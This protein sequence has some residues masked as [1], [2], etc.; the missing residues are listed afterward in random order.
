MRRILLNK[1]ELFLQKKLHTE[2]TVDDIRIDWPNRIIIEN[3]Y[4]P[5]PQNDTL[6][7]IGLL[8]AKIHLLDLLDKEI[9]THHLIAR[10]VSGTLIRKDSI[11][12]FQFI[13]DAFS[14]NEVK[15]KETSS[16]KSGTAL[17]ISPH[18]IDLQN[19]QFNMLDDVSGLDMKVNAGKL[20]MDKGHINFY[21][22][23]YYVDNTFCN[24]ISVDMSISKQT[25]NSQIQSKTTNPLDSIN[26]I[27]THD[28]IVLV[29]NI[30]FNNISYNLDL[31]DTKLNL[32]TSLSNATGKKIKVNISKATTHA[33]LFEVEKPNIQLQMDIP[34]SSPTSKKTTS[35]ST[36]SFSWSNFPWQTEI[37]SF[38]ITEGEFKMDNI[39]YPDTSKSMDFN[40]LNL[41]N[42]NI[43]WK[44][45]YIFNDNYR[46][47]LVHSSFMEKSGLFLKEFKLKGEIL[48]EKATFEDIEIFTNN[49][50][51]QSKL[52]ISYDNI[53]DV[54]LAKNLKSPRLNLTINPSTINLKDISYLFSNKFIN[55]SS[56]SV[57]K[58][59]GTIKKSN[60]SAEAK[61]IL[62]TL[63]DSSIMKLSVNVTNPFDSLKKM[64]IDAKLDTLHLRKIDLEPFMPDNL[65]INLPKTINGKLKID[66]NYNSLKSGL[67]LF[68]EY[69][70]V[71]VKTRM[72]NGYFINDLSLNQINL[73]EILENESLGYL[74]FH[75]IASGYVGSK[76]YNIHLKSIIKNIEFN[77]YN[78]T[79]IHI[80][81]LLNPEKVNAL[82]TSVESGNKMNLSLDLDSLKYI[83]A[84]NL[85]GNIDDLD[86]ITSEKGDTS[87]L[88]TTF[89][90]KSNGISLLKNNSNLDI[91][92]FSFHQ[93][94]NK[95]DFENLNAQ[96]NLDSMKA[97]MLISSPFLE[98][99]FNSIGSLPNITEQLKHLFQ[100]R[101]FA[102]D[103][104]LQDNSSSSYSL[105]GKI[106]SD[107]LLKTGYLDFLDTLSN[108]DFTSK[109][110]QKSELF[111]LNI[112]MPSLSIDS[113]EFDST[114]LTLSNH[115]KKIELNYIT[116]D[117]SVQDSINLGQI[118]FEGKYINDTSNYRFQIINKK[119][120][121]RVDIKGKLITNNG[122]I[123]NTF[124]DKMI[125][126]KRLWEIPKNNEIKI[127]SN[128]VSFQHFKITSGESYIE[129]EDSI[130][131]NKNKFLSVKINQIDLDSI[132]YIP[133]IDKWLVG[134]ELSTKISQSKKEVTGLVEINHLGFLNN[135]IGNLSLD[136]KTDTVQN[137]TYNLHTSLISKITAIKSH[138]SF[139]KDNINGYLNINN[140]NLNKLC[141][142]PPFNNYVKDTEGMVNA[143]LTIKGKSDAPEI[144]GFLELKEIKSTYKDLN[145][146]LYIKYNKILFE[147][148][149]VEINDLTIEDNQKHTIKANGIIDL[150]KLSDPEFNIKTVAD[151]F[152]VM[153][154][155]EKD[156]PIYYGDL[157][158]SNKSEIT[159]KLS[160]L[161][162][163]TTTTIEKGSHV[164]YVNSESGLSKIESS[165]GIVYFTNQL[166][167]VTNIPENSEW[168]NFP[169][170]SLDL[171]LKANIS[172]NQ[173]TKISIILD[174]IS[175][176]QINIEGGGNLSFLYGNNNSLTG[177]FE[178]N[179]G[180]Y[181][182]RLYGIIDK[183][184][185]L[186]KGST[187]TWTGDPL[188]PDLK[189]TALYKIRTSPYPL[190]T[191]N[192]NSAAPDNATTKSQTFY[193]LM[194]ING[195][196]E[197]PE[198]KFELEYPD[199]IPGN[200]A[201]P[202]IQAAINEVN[203]SPNQVNKQAF[204]LILFQ[205][206]ASSSLLE[207]GGTSSIKGTLSSFVT[208]QL[209]N[210][211]SDLLKTKGTELNFNFDTYDEYSEAGR[212]GRSDLN[213][214]VKQRLFN[215]R[216]TIQVG[217]YIR[218]NDTENSNDVNSIAG[219]VEIE[220]KIT[221]DGKYAVRIYREQAAELVFS[222]DVIKTG[223]F[224]IYKKI[225]EEKKKKKKEKQK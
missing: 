91:S 149:K 41:T 82:I 64:G 181:Q 1:G 132:T 146:P 80:N 111:N 29:K 58:A 210:I 105:N 50:K 20:G 214:S 222:P 48:K 65:S 140:L 199:N 15:K 182:L 202:T 144:N 68:T 162:V 35:N 107:F 133:E 16:S 137:I 53:D 135:R 150:E 110:N 152:T 11:F 204:S 220:Y 23:K 176:D 183:T 139:S 221:E 97:N 69:G 212:Q 173:E 191:L 37:K 157:I 31:P 59:K 100:T 38:N 180:S 52:L 76:L 143:Q 94:K 74:N 186:K 219:N 123:I 106:K 126:S 102:H 169:K 163:Q 78:Y 92:T 145:S 224:F 7:H 196:P 164:Y 128:G 159:G 67:R 19:I 138:V 42:M 17:K 121:N 103:S 178:V 158:I 160:K 6:A 207:S 75:G 151:N 122:D 117:I 84:I 40:H 168:Q 93:G 205:T 5:T 86:I 66:G 39:S 77:K 113:I 71:T 185:N 56:K 211:S 148:R 62:L 192:S 161:E 108:I 208:Q 129:I 12:N 101:Q 223:F 57:I 46:M 154:S 33:D 194:Y 79:N 18:N 197:K 177:T 13:I 49:S 203:S 124:N 116:K 213:V 193:V 70:S 218:L 217:S 134:G 27:N 104:L 120:Q 22:K 60:S 142:F 156:N 216:L 118:Q 83:P 88:K 24:N 189:L 130:L 21:T 34:P 125:I 147:D 87:V 206:F 4:L 200:T 30:D 43:E 98:M 127:D 201:D 172:I 26:I 175:Q 153:K 81:S 9:K 25:N 114:N 131:H 44:D 136:L 47:N 32:K 89:K 215:D 45:M 109:F 36:N 51:I 119:K 61:N 141:Q 174:P 28:F 190:L 55:D 166:D 167:T 165:E 2:F 170:L 195:T 198:I 10:N 54:F 99:D 96:I 63:N 95:I 188:N 73:K 187:V 3:L 85:S 155:T 8:D 72:V 90:A 115:K 225:I 184:F 171:D 112:S 14:S 209:N 179:E